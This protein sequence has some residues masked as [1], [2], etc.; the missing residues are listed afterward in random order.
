MQRKPG[1]KRQDFFVVAFGGEE[2][3]HDFTETKI[4]TISNSVFEN[5]SKVLA[6]SF[7]HSALVGY[8]DG[9]GH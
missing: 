5:M 6:S 4:R 3:I 2:I 1:K 9:F 7:C 8:G